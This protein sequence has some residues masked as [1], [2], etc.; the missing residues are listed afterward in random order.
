V[1]IA[2][3]GSPGADAQKN[4]RCDGRSQERLPL[5]IAANQSTNLNR[6]GLPECIPKLTPPFG[7]NANGEL[8]RTRTISWLVYLFVQRTESAPQQRSPPGRGCVIYQ[9]LHSPT[10]QADG[11]AGGFTHERQPRLV[12]LHPSSNNTPSGR[13]QQ[14][15]SQKRDIDNKERVH[16]NRCVVSYL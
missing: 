7:L 10:R 12:N 16:C 6:F 3:S 4:H 15:P 11:N 9:D 2:I 5:P 1:N 13:L 14:S 8:R